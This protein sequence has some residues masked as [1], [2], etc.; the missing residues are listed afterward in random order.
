MPTGM[1]VET[2]P[3]R[4]ILQARASIKPH[5]LSAA[6]DFFVVTAQGRGNWQKRVSFLTLQEK[7][8]TEG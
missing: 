8:G 1:V 5:S 4:P 6:P 3:L 2:Q 7:A